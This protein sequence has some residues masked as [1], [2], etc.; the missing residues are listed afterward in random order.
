LIDGET[1]MSLF[2]AVYTFS[3]STLSL[4]SNACIEDVKENQ[5][6]EFLQLAK[7]QGFTCSQYQGLVSFSCPNSDDRMMRLVLMSDKSECETRPQR[8]LQNL[9]VLMKKE[10]K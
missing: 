3:I 9:R 7:E 8:E 2:L 5:I 4:I 6:P 1:K 10:Y